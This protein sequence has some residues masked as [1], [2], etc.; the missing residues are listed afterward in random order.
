M[1]AHQLLCL[2]HVSAVVLAVSAARIAFRSVV[3]PT[4]FT[5]NISYNMKRATPY[6]LES[7]PSMALWANQLFLSMMDAVSS[8]SAVSTVD[9]CQ[10]VQVAVDDILLQP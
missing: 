3:P 6:G 7:P 5:V 1:F 2:L 9:I 10:A 4:H 8:T